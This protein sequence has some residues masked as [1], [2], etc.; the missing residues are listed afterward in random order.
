[1]S[2]GAEQQGLLDALRAEHAAVFAYGIIAAF[3]NPE[4]A[5]MVGAATAAHRSRRDA[6]IDALTAASVPAPPAEPGYTVPAPV[7][8]PVSA[9]QLAVVVEN[10]TAIA[11]RSAVE[12]AESEPGRQRAVDALTECAVRLGEWRQVL[13]VGPPTVPL[14]G[15]P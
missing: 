10:E 1:M 9:A 2:A 14:P 11:W 8:D 15:Q 5:T 7:T 6:T 12:R 4:R 3:P 13:G